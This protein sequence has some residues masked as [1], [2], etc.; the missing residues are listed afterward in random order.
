[1]TQQ[2]DYKATNKNILEKQ[3]YKC[4]DTLARMLGLDVRDWCFDKTLYNT[5]LVELMNKAHIS[6]TKSFDNLADRINGLI[7]TA[8]VLKAELSSEYTEY[9]NLKEIKYIKHYGNN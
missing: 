7:K 9:K 5:I 2:P 4:V 8:E 1:M 3:I 6:S